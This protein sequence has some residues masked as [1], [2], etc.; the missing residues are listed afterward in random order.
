MITQRILVNIFHGKALNLIESGCRIRK[1]RP[2]VLPFSAFFFIRTKW[3]PD[4]RTI[5]YTPTS[6]AA[7]AVVMITSEMVTQ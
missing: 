3:L 1:M 2:V 5:C 6:L 7:E 4:Q